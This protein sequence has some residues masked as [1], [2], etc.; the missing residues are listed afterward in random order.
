[1]LVNV[2]PPTNDFHAL[3]RYLVDGDTQPPHPDRVAWIRAH[4]LPTDDPELAATYMTATAQ[5][6]KRCKNAA[7]HAMIAWAPHEKPTPDIMQEI[8][9]KTLELAGL[10]EHQALIMGHGDKPHAHLH[11]LINRVHPTTGRAW[12]TKH[13]FALFDRIMRQLSDEYGF[14]YVPAHRFNPDQT[15]DRTKKPNKRATW[16]AKR[17]AKTDRRQWSR[18]ASRAYGATLAERLDRA[19][20]WEDLEAAFAEDGLTLEAKGTGLV[21]GTA[22]SYTKLSALGLTRTAKDFEKRFG[23][24]F[25]RRARPSTRHPPLVRGGRRGHRQGPRQLWPGRQGRR[26]PGHRR[27]QA[28]QRRQAG[29]GAAGHPAHAGIETGHEHHSA[30]VHRLPASRAPMSL[31]ARLGRPGPSRVIANTALLLCPRHTILGTS[32][33]GGGPTALPAADHSSLLTH[34]CHWDDDGGSATRS[35]PLTVYASG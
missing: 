17:G 26:A 10:A 9:L 16:A 29:P 12:D 23:T 8:A 35:C 2:V 19:S 20:T 21:A 34:L 11:M 28:R 24:P 27:I 3:A 1:M 6:S 33:A 5:A 30:H 31:D 4:N 18:N 13:D 15:A 25:P 7:Y 32:G 14:E 22:T